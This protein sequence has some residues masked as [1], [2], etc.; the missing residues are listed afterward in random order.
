MADAPAAGKY[1]M[2]SV[3]LTAEPMDA[4]FRGDDEPIAPSVPVYQPTPAFDR[5]MRWIVDRIGRAVAETLKDNLV[6]LVLGGGYGRGEGGVVVID[7]VEQPYNDLDF[8]LVVRRKSAV[9]A[10]RL[11]A[12]SRRYEEEIHI[13]VDFSR[14][15]TIG[16]IRR[17]PAWLM[18]YDLLNGHIVARGRPDV[19]TAHAPDALNRPLPAIEATRLLLNRGA[20]LLWALRVVRGQEE[21]PD[22][23]FVRRNYFKCALALGDALLIA[24][25]R[26]ATPYTGRDDR[27]RQLVREVE[28]LSTLPLAPLYREALL[29]KFRPDW[30]PD[31]PVPETDLLALAALWGRV[32]LLVEAHRTGRRWASMGDYAAWTGLR[33]PAQHGPA[34]WLRNLVHN[35]RAGR[36]SLTYPREGLYRQLPALLGL[37]GA[38]PD[39]WEDASRAFLEVWKRFN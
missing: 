19:L 3:N 8:T 9:P 23:D 39:R 7:N 35:R 17:W 22:P 2:S 37:T 4:R 25:A 1:I 13:A 33:E 24:W 31:R 14:P 36:W 11:H 27:L 21:T 32:C 5:Y 18:W 20:G 12:I 34:R 38:A 16:D 28:P 29:F 30:T 26:Y 10:D 6:A 15:L